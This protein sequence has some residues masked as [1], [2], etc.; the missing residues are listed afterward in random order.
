MRITSLVILLIFISFNIHGQDRRTDQRVIE[1]YKRYSVEKSFNTWAFTLSYGPMIMYTD[2]TDYS[3]MPKDKIDFGLSATLSKQVAPAFAFD[4]QFLTGDSY[5]EKHNKYFKGNIND[6]SLSAVFFVNQLGAISGPV[7]DKWNFYLKAGAGLVFFRSSLFEE[8][9]D[10]PERSLGYDE[11]GKKTS[12]EM[13]III[14]LSAGFQYRL[15]RSFDIGLESTLRFGEADN[16]DNVLTGSTND[17]YW[18]TGLNLSYK[19]GKKDKR[20]MRWTY[21]GYGF[22]LFNRPIRD[23]LAGETKRFEEDLEKYIEEKPIK[24]DSI[25]FSESLTLIYETVNIRSI[26]FK[27]AG[28]TQFDSDDIISMAEIVVLMK[29][30]PDSKLKLYGY[31]AASDEGDHDKLSLD[32]CELV[33]DIL[34]NEL[35]ADAEKIEII[36]RGSKDMLQA[37]KVSPN[38]LPI[39]F[40]RRVDLVLNL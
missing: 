34:V 16:L 6:L 27:E 35:G 26:F 19:I 5:G 24:R 30:N 32:Q 12:R 38:K 31:V 18:F 9:S 10:F 1:E 7:R 3:L 40:N 39:N 2:I 17:R 4:L 21:R 28:K 36:N 37:N 25:T 14:P 15:N 22:N 11:I 8:G 13:D 33:K 20:H 23:P 29:L